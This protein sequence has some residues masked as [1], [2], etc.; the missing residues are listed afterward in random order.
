M[1]E[2]TFF[3]FEPMHKKAV[4]GG[5]RLADLLGRDL[6]PGEP[7]WAEDGRAVT[8]RTNVRPEHD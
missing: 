8:A 7:A 4:W 5:R 2:M 1:P 6:P 3:R